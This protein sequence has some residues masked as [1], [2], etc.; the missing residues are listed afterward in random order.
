MGYEH[1]HQRAQ[2]Q[3]HVKELRHHAG[4]LHAQQILGDGQMAG[5]GDRQELR[6]ALDEA[7]QKG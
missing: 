5:A 3:Q 6:D 1:G 4:I 7:Q 2:V